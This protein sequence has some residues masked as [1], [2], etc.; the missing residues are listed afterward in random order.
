MFPSA[1]GMPDP[2]NILT[3]IDNAFAVDLQI[4]PGGDVFY[5][6]IAS[7]QIRRIEYFSANQP[8]VAI[9][10]ADVQNGPSPLTVNFDGFGSYDPDPADT[11][12]F[13]WDLD[14]DGDFDDSTLI[15]PQY[16]YEASGNYVAALRVT[17]DSGDSD[18]ATLPITVDNSPPVAT[19]LS[20]SETD[21]WRVGDVIFFSGQGDD[22]DTRSA[23]GRGVHLAIFP[24]ALCP[25][26]SVL[27][28]M[29]I[30]SKNSAG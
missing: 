28:V 3:F 2:G 25:P 26:G 14:G 6:D 19:I 9:A 10:G 12:S 29:N 24:A 27:T 5:V 17:D 13:F 11:L 4:G 18:T 23:A 7:G 16:T 21:T 30:S 20:P 8:P 15:D 22:P 1:G